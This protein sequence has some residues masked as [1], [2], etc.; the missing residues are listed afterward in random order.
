MLR[1]HRPPSPQGYPLGDCRPS[2]SWPLL[3]R[4]L[5]SQHGLACSLSRAASAAGSPPARAGNSLPCPLLQRQ[6]AS[7]HGLSC[8]GR[9]PALQ[10]LA[11][12]LSVAAPAAA[13]HLPAWGC[14][15]C[16][17]LPA[18]FVNIQ[19]SD[20]IYNDLPECFHPWWETSGECCEVRKYCCN[21]LITQHPDHET[22]SS[23]C[24]RW[25]CCLPL[26]LS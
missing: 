17:G 3:K 7:L 6:L 20:Y 18:G 21:T 13:G 2:F 12:P 11:S 8:S 24:C 5:A 22:E 10:A 1:G 25:Q 23:F 4:Q 15:R 14:S 9:L 26:A 16:R 19:I